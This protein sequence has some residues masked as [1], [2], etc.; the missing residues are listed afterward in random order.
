MCWVL[1]DFGYGFTLETHALLTGI[2]AI[3]AADRSF[4][5]F[6]SAHRYHPAQ[7]CKK[8]PKALCVGVTA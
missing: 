6:Y 5:L 7:K 2:N 4:H 8:R 1:P 3:A